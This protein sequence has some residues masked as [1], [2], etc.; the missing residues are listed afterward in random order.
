M[1]L[2]SIE[3]QASYIANANYYTNWWKTVSWFVVVTDLGLLLLYYA[4]KKA[5][6]P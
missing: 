2:R 5:N 3:K 6:P 4:S 1:E